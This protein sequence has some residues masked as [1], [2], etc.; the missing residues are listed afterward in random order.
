[1]VALDFH[2]SCN[3]HPRYRT[4]RHRE[5]SA[6]RIK[7][8][9]RIANGNR[10]DPQHPKRKEVEVTPRRYARLRRQQRA[11]ENEARTESKEAVKEGVKAELPNPKKKSL[12]SRMVG[13]AKKLFGMN[14]ARGG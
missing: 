3:P 11:I 9:A 14:R 2:D 4:M 13:T 6:R 12:G 10:P 7:N 1:M 5:R 8:L